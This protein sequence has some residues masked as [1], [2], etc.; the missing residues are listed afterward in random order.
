MCEDNKKDPESACRCGESFPEKTQHKD[1]GEATGK[2]KEECKN[3]EPD[4]KV[5]DDLVSK[6]KELVIYK[7]KWLRAMAEYENLKKRFEKEKRE[8]IQFTTSDILVQLLSII[9]DFD[10]AH[11]AAKGHKHGEV[12]SKGV[13]MI[14]NQLHK[15]L[16]DNGVEK[17]KT[18]GE[19]FDPNIHDAVMTI[20]SDKLPEDSVAEELYPGY[21]LNGRLLRAA[22]VKI[23]HAKKADEDIKKEGDVDN[24][25]SK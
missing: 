15:L 8:I 9:D 25:Q 3:A 14:L 7:D 5:Y 13:K 12:F 16:G 20:E 21:L 22:K 2:K 1:P 17:I 6:E 11:S 19:K 18:V 4:T 23:S 24:E 10:R